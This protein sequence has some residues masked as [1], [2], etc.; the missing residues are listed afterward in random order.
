[1]LIKQNSSEYRN[2]NHCYYFVILFKP[3]DNL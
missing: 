3:T 2:D 1:M